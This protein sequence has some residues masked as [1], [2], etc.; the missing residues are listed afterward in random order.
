MNKVKLVDIKFDVS[1]ALQGLAKAKDAIHQAI[2][3]GVRRAAQQLLRDC[4]PYIPMLTGALRDSGRVEQLEDYAFML[5][6]D[7]AN[8]DNGYIYASKQY[9]E[10]LQ[11]V[12]GRYA[13]KWVRRVLSNNKDYYL[14]L[15]AKYTGIEM[16]RIFER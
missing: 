15:A 7:A 4:K 10:V 16:E 1:S 12:D 2:T 8:P 11:H 9:D 5:V 13:A 6:W 3:R 14:L